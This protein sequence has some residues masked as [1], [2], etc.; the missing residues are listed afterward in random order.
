MTSVVPASGQLYEDY[1]TIAAK[2]TT[3][4]EILS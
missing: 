2:Q 3:Y 1:V 4:Q